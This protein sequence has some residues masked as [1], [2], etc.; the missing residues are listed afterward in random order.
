MPRYC[1]KTNMNKGKVKC[2]AKVVANPLQNYFICHSSQ[3]VSSLFPKDW[4]GRIY[5]LPRIL[6]L[7]IPD[8]YCDKPSSI[9][10]D[11][12]PEVLIDHMPVATI[13]HPANPVRHHR[14][15]V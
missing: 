13:R 7:I 11:L 4:I 1:R 5:S 12:C 9:T 15:A 8:G 10:G 3:S 2:A 14:S 6:L